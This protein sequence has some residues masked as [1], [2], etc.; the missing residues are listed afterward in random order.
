MQAGRKHQ[1]VKLISTMI[2]NKSEITDQVKFI[3]KNDPRKVI[4]SYMH[5]YIYS[6]Q[7]PC[8]IDREN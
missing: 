7:F 8:G 5:T 3:E 4:E 2:E 6:R 1:N